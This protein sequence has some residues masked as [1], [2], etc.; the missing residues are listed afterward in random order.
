MT[1]PQTASTAVT[2]NFA[3]HGAPASA[4]SF[5]LVR[6]IAELKNSTQYFTT[7]HAAHTLVKRA[8][9]RVVLIVLR[10][11][12][13]LKEHRT[14]QPVSLQTLVG[15]IRVTL[16]GRALEQGVDGLMVIEPG[17]AHEVSAIT[18]SAILLSMPWSEHAEE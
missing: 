15:H 6:E 10:R 9:L 12:A 14:N 16:P 5:D 4:G 1:P 7:G 13:E 18:D 2:A 3:A 8:D 17:L 11:D